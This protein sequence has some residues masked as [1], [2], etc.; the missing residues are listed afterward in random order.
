MSERDLD[1]D[2][3]AAAESPEFL[4][5]IFVDMDF[6]GENVRVHNGVGTYSFGGNDYMGVGT[7]GSVSPVRESIELVDQPINLTLSGIDTTII[8]ILRSVNITGR[9]VEIFIGVLD[10]E[11]QLVGT[12]QSMILAEVDAISVIAGKENAVQLS[13]QTRAARLRRRNNK[14]WT[15]EHHQADYPG[16]LFFE[17][18]PYVVAAEVQWGGERVRTGYRNNDDNLGQGVTSTPDN[19]GDGGIEGG[20][21]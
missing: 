20:R 15:L 18:L 17:F 1:S 6:P 14:R 3:K 5:I 19:P 7:F 11:A 13:L 2:L 8:N 12:P 4:Y 9:D 21:K 10:K 16:D